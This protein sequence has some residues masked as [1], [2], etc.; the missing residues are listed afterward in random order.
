MFFLISD[1]IVVFNKTYIVYFDLKDRVT[2]LISM[3]FLG[4]WFSQL[5]KFYKCLKMFVCS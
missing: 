1:L 4:V 3:F 5:G 2:N